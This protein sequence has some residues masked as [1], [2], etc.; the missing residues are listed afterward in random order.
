MMACP[1]A[2]MAQNTQEWA[3]VEPQSGTRVL[4]DNVGFL[5]TADADDSFSVVCND[6][7]V[8][9][10]ARE[11]NFALVDPT[12]IES[13]KT[14]NNGILPTLRGYVDGQLTLAG[15]RAGT[16]AEVFDAGGRKVCSAQCDGT[17][18]AVDVTGLAPGVY[19]LRA[20]KTAIKFVKK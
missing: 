16:V 9:Y 1:A 20:G 18:L 15:C 17:E 11:V 13:P 12:G 8:I 5:L 7:T 6:G 19:M 4:M 3:L 14:E 10:G 2:I